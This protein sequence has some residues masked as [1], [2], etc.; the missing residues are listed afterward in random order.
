MADYENERKE[1]I[2]KL[3]SQIKGINEILQ[4]N[5]NGLLDR[6]VENELLQIKDKVSVLLRKLENNEFEISIV[7]VEKAGKSSFAN[8]MMGNN[9]LPSKEA[10][11]TYTATNI[12]YGDNKATVSFFSHEEFSRGFQEK[13]KML[14]VEHPDTYS[15]ETLSL[16]NYQRIFESLDEQTRRFYGGKVNK[17]IEDILEYKQSLQQYIGSAPKQF[18]G[19]ELES[20][21][22]KD[23]IQTPRCAIAVKE[24]T[25]YSDK[26]QNM[27]NAIIYDVPGFDSPTQ[28]HKEQTLQKMRA[29][30]AIVLIASA[31]KPSFTGPVVDM[32]RNTDEDGIQFGDKMFVFANMADRAENLNDNMEDIC[33]DLQ[34]HSIMK[35]EYFSQR[36]IAGSARAKLET[37]GK[38][39]GTVASDALKRMNLADGIDK[40][41][42]MLE[43]YNKKDR[44]EVLKRKINRL[45]ND[46]RAVFKEKFVRDAYSDFDSGIRIADLATKCVDD[47]RDSIKKELEYYL[48]TF[49]KEYTNQ[50]QPLTNKMKTNVISQLNVEKYG[51]KDDEYEE[52]LNHNDSVTQV[53]VPK[54]VDSDLRKRKYRMIYNAFS[55]GV[56]NV[57]V[58]EHD[59]CDKE[60]EEI[61]EKGLHI[62][63]SNPYYDELKNEILEFIVAQR[64][65][66]D[67][68]GY[69]KSLVERFSVDLFETLIKY[70][71][72]D[73]S[74]WNRFD[75][76]RANFYSL[77]MYSSDFDNYSSPDQQSMHYK[78]LFHSDRKMNE[79]R[80]VRKIIEFVQDVISCAVG[81]D[82]LK[83]I[84]PIVFVEG[85]KALEIVRKELEKTDR[86]KESDKKQ[87]YVISVL[88]NI[89][90]RY[91]ETDIDFSETALSKETYET[92]FNG[93]RDKTTDDVRAEIDEDIKILQEMLE[94][95]V[96]KAIYIEKPFL[97]LETQTIGNLID[98]LGSDQYRQLVVNNIHKLYVNEYSDL[99]AN[100]QKQI[101]YE[102]MMEQI[103]LII[104]SMAD[105]PERREYKCE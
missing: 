95:T 51:V 36:V 89:V 25:I 19:E 49:K 65:V 71:Y 8:A 15:Y 86:N 97:A 7:G 102:K 30:D 81:T 56:V 66:K 13:L 32:F 94:D 63:K 39:E 20:D 61:F 38:V 27:K 22:F 72:G 75:N 47:S 83:Y 105:T 48:Q 21:Y 34:R 62:S 9:I 50:N 57:A 58:E 42:E 77:S 74:R 87:K 5:T 85:D 24:I 100:Q 79:Q 53:L 101:A 4:L 67:S 46:I 68:L 82:I 40:M 17:D 54:D 80:N 44:F 92:F 26:L 84:K 76:D 1:Y 11:C 33:N 43:E 90:D 31:Y 35:P 37:V 73:M 98:A 16:N 70:S 60:I 55:D 2:G 93:K 12:R 91:S 69:Y 10:R 78:I 3:K 29:A 59:K 6:S 96:V 14:G 104:D 64:G 88:E 23:F 103:E 99:R 18:S 41:I 52:A 28:M 45:Q